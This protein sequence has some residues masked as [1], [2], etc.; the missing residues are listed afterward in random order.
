[1][2]RRMVILALVA[3]FFVSMLPATSMIAQ[4]IEETNYE[5]EF[6]V[7]EIDVQTEEDAQIMDDISNSY[8]EMEIEIEAEKE[9]EQHD[10]VPPFVLAVPTSTVFLAPGSDDIDLWM[11]INSALPGIPLVI[12]LGTDINIMM[13]ARSTIP[14]DRIIILE[15]PYSLIANGNFPVVTVNGTFT[16]DGPTLTRTGTIGGTS[17]G[18]RVNPTGHFTMLDGMITG[19]SATAGGGVAI[20]LL[21]SFDDMDNFGEATDGVF[22]M[23][24]GTISGNTATTAGGGG[25]SSGGTFIMYGGTISGN[26]ALS[27]G[28]GGGVN[29]VGSSNNF[30]G[31]VQIPNIAAFV[32]HGGV[33][34]DN[35]SR[36]NAGGGVHVGID[37][38]F[39]MYDGAYI[40]GNTSVSRGGGINFNGT[41]TMNGGM[42]NGNVATTDGGGLSGMGS[43]TIN[44]GTISDNIANI[45]GGGV[46]ADGLVT[47]WGGIISNNTAYGTAANQGG[48]G[49]FATN[50]GGFVMHGGEVSR[51]TA[52]NDGGGIFSTRH[53][54]NYRVPLEP[55][56]NADYVNIRINEDAVFTGNSARFAVAPHDSAAN[57]DHR[58]VSRNTSIF[59]HL[60]NNYDI[61]FAPVN[62]HLLTFQPG[63]NG[64]LNGG[65]VDVAFYVYS[66]TTLNEAFIPAPAP[67]AGWQ[68]D[69]WRYI[70]QADDALNLDN[71]AIAAVTVT[72]SHTFAAQWVQVHTVT[73]NLNGG[74]ST[75]PSSQAVPHDTQAT[76]PADPI[77]INYTFRAWT[78]DP[79][80]ADIWDF[81]TGVTSDMT[82]YAQWTP[83]NDNDDDED[84]PGNGEQAPGGGEEQP[85]GGEQPSGGGQQTPPVPRPPQTPQ[86]PPTVNMRER[87]AYLIGRDDG[88]IRPHADITRAE[89]ATI[90]FRLI[91]D[92]TRVNYWE[93]TNPFAD[94]VLQNWFNN[95]VSTTTNAGI[96]SGF[97]NGTF[98][99]NQTITR[100]ELTA[101]VVRFMGGTAHTVSTENSF[102]DISGHWAREYINTAAENGWVQGADGLGGAFNPNRPITRAE[103]AAIINRILIRLAESPDDLLRD[104]ML[105]W[106]D[107]ANENA[108]YFLYMQSASNSYQYE[109]RSCDIFSIWRA[110]IQPRNWTVLE[111]PD[112][113]PEDIWR[114]R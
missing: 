85:G 52:A 75:A 56:L 93:Q 108:W 37:A 59:N 16:L 18:V 69:G 80:G 97:P 103:T 62:R 50:W 14:A 20:P 33:I 1:M 39:A 82:L 104:Y 35:H 101:A 34:S 31:G 13:S 76:R 71:A 72:D 28:L 100:G 21:F 5:P 66:G 111:R 27:F 73:F 26:E 44:N 6:A 12:E 83:D 49:V 98:A 45:N 79:A 64:T 88:L 23:V 81:A 102:N 8:P 58:L 17:N 87:Q 24:G 86:S 67:S 68:F 61:N 54:L 40:S 46:F 48:G 47:M 95:A 90:F 74:T 77:R 42:I 10:E 114:A 63:T 30:S 7:P 19:N 92:E 4:M 9:A 53:P 99:P 84:E 94:V 22:I 65:T 36:G 25:V 70:G 60:L 38:T 107:N 89:V 55:S 106:P 29:T 57:L 32:M 110:I 91:S 113:S 2:K 15:G 3:A 105:T 109:M 112:S 41:V 96:F 51:N 11:A 43:L 78:T